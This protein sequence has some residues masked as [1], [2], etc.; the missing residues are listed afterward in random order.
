MIQ[1]AES[2]NESQ[3]SY[4]GYGVK[5]AGEYMLCG[6]EDCERI[7]TEEKRKCSALRKISKGKEPCDNL[8]CLYLCIYQ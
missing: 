5:T 6:D 4:E 8:P 7:W 3:E 2:G 1:G